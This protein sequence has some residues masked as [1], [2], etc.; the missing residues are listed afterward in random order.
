[1]RFLLIFFV[2]CISCANN[3]QVYI[4][5]VNDYRDYKN[6]QFKSDP[7]SP[8]SNR[9]KFKQLNYF[10]VDETFKVV[11]VLKELD[12][13]S[14]IILHANENVTTTY[15]KIGVVEFNL[16]GVTYKL[17]AF[18]GPGENKNRIFIPF[19]DLTSGKSSYGAGRFLY[20]I[21]KEEENV[22]T[23]DFNYAHNPYCAYNPN[24]SCPL[25]PKEN[26]INLAIKAGEKK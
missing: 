8:I 17:S 3:N 22:Y 25:P 11:G 12:F 2:F 26:F 9:E 10:E 24:F 19:K 13:P 14:Y 1:M 4:Q 20:A 23:I 15:E 5:E 7:Q 18:I 21:K 6:S 16:M